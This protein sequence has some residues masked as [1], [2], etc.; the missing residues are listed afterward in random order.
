[1]RLYSKLLLSSICH[2]HVI[3][4]Y[5]VFVQVQKDDSIDVWI[6]P[7]P[8]NSALAEVERYEVGLLLGFSLKSPELCFRLYWFTACLFR[9]E[10][11]WCFKNFVLGYHF[12]L[13]MK[14]LVNRCVGRCSSV[15]TLLMF[16]SVKL[17]YS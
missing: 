13:L 7:Y 5:S 15:R 12:W 6:G 10:S 16:L 2:S 17:S 4:C 8:E 11:G 14:C 3:D 9:E 1:M